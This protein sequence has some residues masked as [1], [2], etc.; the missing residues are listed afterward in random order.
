MKLGVA[1][2][3][4]KQV[5]ALVPVESLRS[6]MRGAP[7]GLAGITAFRTVHAAA[8]GLA[9]SSM[10]SAGGS[11]S[12]GLASEPPPAAS[13][14][15]LPGRR[16]RRRRQRAG[17]PAERT[18]AGC[19]N[20]VPVQTT[21]V[22]DGRYE[23]AHCSARGMA[24]PTAPTTGS[25]GGRSP[26]RSWRPLRPRPSLRRAVPDARPTRGRAW[27]PRTSWPCSIRGP[28]TASTTSSPSSWRARR[29]PS[30]SAATDRPR[31]TRPSRS[32]STSRGPSPRR[33][34]GE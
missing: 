28:T 27:P 17:E 4:E 9:L 32:A 10:A 18:N 24:R 26:S 19:G 1:D 7:T 5:R 6:P 29:S 25:C 3:V 33:T 20:S 23:L 22:L 8:P 30:G 31:P 12:G 11:T 15:A 2:E 16:R 14:A 21:Q 13:R 34:S